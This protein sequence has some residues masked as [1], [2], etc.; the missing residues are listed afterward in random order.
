MEQ[1]YEKVLVG[2]DLQQVE[3]ILATTTSK[4]FYRTRADW[5]KVGGDPGGW[6]EDVM[7]IGHWELDPE[8]GPSVCVLFDGAGKVVGVEYQTFVGGDS[9]LGMLRRLR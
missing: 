7:A 4:R 6:P 8:P 1:H 3:S 9:F 2:K 5:E